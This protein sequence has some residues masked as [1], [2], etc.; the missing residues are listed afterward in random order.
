MQKMLEKLMA[1]MEDIKSTRGGSAGSGTGGVSG[2]FRGG[3]SA[4]P[5]EGEDVTGDPDEGAVREEGDREEG[6][7]D[8]SSVADDDQDPDDPAVEGVEAALEGEEGEEELDENGER[9][10]KNLNQFKKSH[11]QT[12]KKATS[13]DAVA[14]LEVN[15]TSRSL[16]PINTPCSYILSHTPLSS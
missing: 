10:I 15:M 14:V 8:K 7:D 16:H 5:R 12:A 4:T 11:S 2:S 3:V 6:D 1:G 13:D 9:R